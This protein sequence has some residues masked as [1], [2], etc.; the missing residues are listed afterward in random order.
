MVGIEDEME[1]IGVGVKGQEA[2]HC[3]M[4]PPVTSVAAQVPRLAALLL[5][6]VKSAAVPTYRAYG[7]LATLAHGAHVHSDPLQ[8]DALPQLPKTVK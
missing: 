7:E 3:P 2:E 8:S 4:M 5:P 1:V 6:A